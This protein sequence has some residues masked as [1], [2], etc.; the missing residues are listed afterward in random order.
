M[1]FSQV[2]P[3]LALFWKCLG[4]IRGGFQTERW[5]AAALAGQNPRPNT[6]GTMRSGGC[7]AWG[8]ERT[9]LAPAGKDLADTV[10]FQALILRAGGW[11]HTCLAELTSQLDN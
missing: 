10:S 6:P 3:E 4:S 11:V 8:G 5:P 1:L 9:P 2:S 7:L